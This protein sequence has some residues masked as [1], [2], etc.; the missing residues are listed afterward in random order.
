MKKL[1][2]LSLV[3]AACQ[4]DTRNIEKKIDDLNKKMDNLIA[5]GG[6]GAGQPRPAPRPEPDKA[7]TYAVPIEGDPFEGRAD[8]KITVVKGYDYACGYCEKVRGTMEDLKKKYGADLR[9]VYKQLVIHPKQAMVGALAFCAAGKQ[10]KAIEMDRMLWDKGFNARQFDLTDVPVT[11]QQ[12]PQP[13]QPQPQQGQKPAEAPGQTV[14]CWDHPDGCKNVYAWASELGLNMDKLKADMKGDCTQQV[15]T[16][17]R[18]LAQ[19]AVSSTP[20][21]FINGRYI[22]GAQP[23]DTFVQVIDDELKKANE[24]IAAGTPAASYY[25][26]WVMDKGLKSLQQ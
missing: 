23:L 25:Q 20:A 17:G 7:K 3:L 9:I 2:L 18:Q 5:R 1:V 24:R 11:G 14:K 26:Q 8:A 15:A 22:S 6:V 13:Q 16:D 4:S 12:P 21:F 10:G 19:F